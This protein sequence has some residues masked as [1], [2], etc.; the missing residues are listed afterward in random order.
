MDRLPLTSPCHG[1]SSPSPQWPDLCRLEDWFC[2]SPICSSPLV[3]ASHAPILLYHR[4]FSFSNESS[5]VPFNHHTPECSSHAPTSGS[6][7]QRVGPMRRAASVEALLCHY[8]CV[9]SFFLPCCVTSCNFPTLL[10]S[11]YPNLFSLQT[12]C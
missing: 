1:V 3:Q 10:L 7:R 8:C 12:F 2:N 5:E 9:L 6:M 4:R 11:F